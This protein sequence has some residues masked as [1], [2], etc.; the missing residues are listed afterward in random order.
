MRFSTTAIISALA[1]SAAAQQFPT[2][3]T[4]KPPSGNPINLP[5][6][7]ENLPKNSKY[8]ISW[9]P[10]STGSNVALVLLRGCPKNC[11]PVL[12]LAQSIPNSGSFDWT[13]QDSIEPD[14]TYGIEL[15]VESDK[16]YQYSNHFI[17]SGSSAGS[18]GSNNAPGN[19]PGAPANTNTTTATVIY[20][21]GSS[22]FAT[23][24]SATGTGNVTIPV[25]SPTNPMTVPGTLQ[26]TVT[27]TVTDGG[28]SA[29]DTG[30][31]PSSLPTGAANAVN[32][33]NVGALALAGLA[34]AAL[35]L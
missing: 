6:Q 4:S 3:D 7:D 9:G 5:K 20:A 22:G 16:S 14:T 33:R 8:T 26:P 27:G 13:V 29:S 19:A 17:I 15:I 34:V 2:A 31:A 30:S 11:L 10:T 35:V 25:L 18:Q 28:S 32:A 1:A 23:A 12:T 21:T 24:P